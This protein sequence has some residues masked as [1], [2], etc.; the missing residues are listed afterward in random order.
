MIYSFAEHR[1]ERLANNG[2]TPIWLGD[3]KRLIFASLGKMYLLDIRTRQE[4]EI[5]N[6]GQNSFGVFALSRDN[7][8]LY[9]SLISTEADIHLLSLN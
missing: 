4:R 5:H 9:Y 8:R 2:V 6:V 7:R 3:S 1:Y